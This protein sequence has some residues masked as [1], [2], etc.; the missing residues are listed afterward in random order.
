MFSNLNLTAAEVHELQL[1]LHLRRRLLGAKLL[2]V[3]EELG[4][5]HGLGLLQKPLAD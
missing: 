2:H 1:S 4:L 3:L 5:G